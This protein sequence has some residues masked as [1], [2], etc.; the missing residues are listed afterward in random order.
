VRVLR[1][2]SSTRNI[3]NPPF[4]FQ[5]NVIVQTQQLKPLQQQQQQMSVNLMPVVSGQ[6][7]VTTLPVLNASTSRL[8]THVAQTAPLVDKVQP[9]MA[10]WFN[11]TQQA[12]TTENLTHQK[13][14][15]SLPQG[16]SCS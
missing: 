5:T 9:N 11:P 14:H 2:S 1:L 3:I 13:Q 7:V 12:S 15:G 10:K 8:V 16:R 4:V 6:R